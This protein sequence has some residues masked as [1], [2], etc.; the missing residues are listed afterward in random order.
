MSK[1][2]WWSRG[3]VETKKA[4]PK[5]S[6]ETI[7]RARDLGADDDEIDD[8]G[9]YRQNSKGHV[10]WIP[11]DKLVHFL[12]EN[13]K[14]TDDD[15]FWDWFDQWVI[16]EKLGKSRGHQVSYY[17]YYD[18]KA[19]PKKNYLTDWWHGYGYS[20]SGGG[21]DERKLAIALGA[22]RTTVSV[23]NDSGKKYSVE[24]ADDSGTQ[25][26]SYT[27][28]QDR[29]IVVSPQALLDSSVNESDGIEISSGFGLHEASHAQYSEST[30]KALMEPTE[31]TPITVTSLLHNLLEDLR[32]ERLTSA[33]FPGFESYFDEANAY[34]WKKTSAHAPREWGGKD[35][36]IESKLGSIIGSAKWPVEYGEIV[37]ASSD[38]RLKDEYP[39]WKDWGQRYVQGGD[40]RGLLVEAMNR[41]RADPETAKQLA[42]REK[43]EKAFEKSQGV[44]FTDMGDEEFSQWLEQMRQQLKAQTKLQPCPSHSGGQKMKLTQKQ[45]EQINKMVREELQLS[46][47]N[48]PERFADAT[49]KAP[50]TVTTRPEQDANRWYQRPDPGLVARMKSAFFFRKAAPSWSERLLKAG[51]IDDE[52]LYR[53]ASGD[54]R[55]FE[56]RVVEETPD[57]QV[58]LLI[59]LSGSMGGTNIENAQ[60]MATVML[61]CLRLMKGAT[62]RVRGHRSGYS[63]GCEVFRIWEPGD[64]V[65]RLGLLRQLN[66]GGNY[67]GY[68][69]DYCADELV[70][71]SK[72]NESK[73]LIVLSDGRPNGTAYGGESAESHVHRVVEHYEKKDVTIIQIAID[74]AVGADIQA[75]MFK[76]FI[77]FTNGNNLP[78]QLTKLLVKLFST[79][80]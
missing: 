69:I 2:N 70:K 14:L 54:Y 78:A 19:A 6:A 29:R 41:L 12:E 45:A 77:P 63:Y 38:Q 53:V 60:A 48:V 75:Q 24:F 43:Q 46:Q 40:L 62:V 22:I 21:Q 33:K 66:G 31:L 64:P 1:S 28:Y 35:G 17:D 8:G 58:T 3:K 61:E 34:L 74:P 47:P 20:G 67:D 37:D 71:V 42:E 57:T 73:V 50:D 7:R 18:Y 26:Q 51:S 23:I 44:D 5:Y 56:R 55:V 65:Q 27:A 59:D 39:W 32:I 80:A 68:A 76:H 49:G 13:E 52:E 36:T 10:F 72:A 16:D 30:V 11:L 15:A 79:P 25:P 9:G 4:D